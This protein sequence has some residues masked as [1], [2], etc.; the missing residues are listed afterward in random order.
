MQAHHVQDL[1][2]P[3]DARKEGRCIEPRETGAQVFASKSHNRYSLTLRSYTT[4][5]AHPTA[6]LQHA[7]AYL[8]FP[9]FTRHVLQADI[10]SKRALA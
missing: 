4:K 1:G 10:L 7:E 9:D 8:P 6:L 2:A 3:S 5:A